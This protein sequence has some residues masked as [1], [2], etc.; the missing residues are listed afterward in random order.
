MSIIDKWREL[1]AP[2]REEIMYGVFHKNSVLELGC[3]KG[4]LASE[5]YQKNPNIR[6]IG[7]DLD[8]RL[9]EDARK[10]LSDYNHRLFVADASTF[11]MPGNQTVDAVVSLLL[12]FPLNIDF[13]GVGKLKNKFHETAY[14][15]LSKQGRYIFGTSSQNL[16]DELLDSGFGVMC[17]TPIR[18][19]GV[20]T[21]HIYDCEKI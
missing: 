19:A 5:I 3:G 21:G 4:E 11:R 17:T 9:V 6:Y 12:M 16:E 20:F 1:Q 18:Y 14:N 10:N 13:Y 7:V 2:L 8:P 15:A